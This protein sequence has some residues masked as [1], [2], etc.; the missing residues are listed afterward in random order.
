MI[1]KFLIFVVLWGW[2]LALAAGEPSLGPILRIE[3]GFHTA[4][5]NS[6]DAVRDGTI[7]TVSK[8][9]TARLW[10]I[11]GSDFVQERVLRVPIPLDGQE[12]LYG[13]ALSPDGHRVALA[14]RAGERSLVLIFDR[15]DGSVVQ[16]IQLPGT[17]NKLRYRN[18]GGALA[19]CLWRGVCVI[20][21]HAGKVQWQDCSYGDTSCGCIW[22]PDGSVATTCLDGKIRKYD[23]QGR[24]VLTVASKIGKKPL[25]IAGDGLRGL[26]VG[27]WDSTTV[28]Q[29]SNDLNEMPALDIKGAPTGFE[30]CHLGRVAWAAN[31]WWAAGN[32]RYLPQGPDAPALWPV[33]M[34]ST[35]GSVECDGAR[36][37]VMDLVE[38][39]GFGQ[40]VVASADPQLLLLSGEGNALARRNGVSVDMRYKVG[41][42]LTVSADGRCV[43]FGIGR[44]IRNPVCLDLDRGRLVDSPQETASL[45]YARTESNGLE[46]K[47]WIN[48][49]SPTLN[50]KPISLETHEVVR[51]LAISP[52]GNTAIL[53]CA[54]S[55]RSFDK[56][57]TQLWSHE[58]PEAWG[59]N[60][61]GD[62]RAIIVALGDGQ[63]HLT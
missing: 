60:V 58:V 18:D 38:R 23:I 45:A 53:G 39:P 40:V 21:V 22:L 5:I 49:A 57:G 9:N 1:A 2:G 8:D 20:D 59:V 37:T 16:Q 46:V 15:I 10:R 61:S 51:S 52:D 30:A 48:G 27:F 7:L 41:D 25:T 36:N 42:A 50:G 3:S 28:A 12:R 11:E 47:D 17:P 26:A 34:W 4:A 33:I 31:R 29:F 14:V 43:R 13:G 24:N 54:W 44:G 32:Y 63:W 62:G 35:S 6:V 55:L 19:A 56:H